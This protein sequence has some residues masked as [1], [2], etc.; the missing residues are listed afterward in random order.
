MR[1]GA[2]AMKK[3]RL[4]R[5]PS[6][7]AD[8]P[9]PLPEP[10]PSSGIRVAD[11]GRE[12][13]HWRSIPSGESLRSLAGRT[14]RTLHGAR[15]DRQ[16]GYFARMRGLGWPVSACALGRGD[17]WPPAA[18]SLPHEDDPAIG[19]SIRPGDFAKPHPSGGALNRGDK[20]APG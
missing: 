17:G 3:V 13:F 5:G 6:T 12:R 1:M 9:F 20:M 10:A 8:P 7:Q 4:I 16:E 18:F 19:A 11:E 2:S 15:G 14:G